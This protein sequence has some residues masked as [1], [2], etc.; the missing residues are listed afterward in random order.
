MDNTNRQP[1][2]AHAAA[3]P[4][5]PVR[6]PRLVSLLMAAASLSLAAGCASFNDAAKNAP[7][8]S[9]CG[10]SPNNHVD[11][12][13]DWVH[14]IRPEPEKSV[15]VDGKTLRAMEVTFVGTPVPFRD[16]SGACMW[17][18]PVLIERRQ[19]AAQVYTCIADMYEVF[20]RDGRIQKQPEARSGTAR[21]FMK[22]LS[23]YGY[24]Y[25]VG[26]SFKP[27]EPGYTQGLK[28]AV[29]VDQ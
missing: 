25:L 20:I 4:P 3:Q 15:V 18:V 26:Y 29:K 1:S 19:M 9:Q 21:D 16:S 5:P 28:R 8:P 24:G 11:L 14:Q 27:I 7:D 10:P 6:L 22:F 13:R 23:K 2:P 12:L 17:V